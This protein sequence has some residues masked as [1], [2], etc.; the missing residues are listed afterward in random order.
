MTVNLDIPVI[1]KRLRL[2]LPRFRQTADQVGKAIERT[3][4]DAASRLGNVS[5]PSVD[6]GG[7]L[8]GAKRTI[9]Q[10]VRTLSDGGQAVAS[11][12]ERAATG[13]S[14]RVRHLGQDVDSTIQDLRSLRITRDSGRD[15]WPG[16][17]LIMGVVGGVVAMFLFDPRDGRRRRTVLRDK[18]GKWGRAASR[19]ARGKAVDLRNRSQGVI[20]EAK[21]AIGGVRGDEQ[22]AD[23]YPSAG[24]HAG[25]SGDWDQGSE[26]EAA[27]MG[28][29][30]VGAAV[31]AGAAEP[32]GGEYGD[33]AHRPGAPNG[34]PQG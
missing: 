6:L 29:P 10:T 8:E 9:D 20:H 1:N 28:Q 26:S 7:A 25:S 23:E 2:E 32:N 21:S 3:S 11:G 15:P 4:D 27:A 13:A 34:H 33:L 22:Q 14:V 19:E 12:A 31:G 18:L 24:G 17:A 5:L 30:A 16:V